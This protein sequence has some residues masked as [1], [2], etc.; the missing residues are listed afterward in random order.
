[1]IRTLRRL[2]LLALLLTAALILGSITPA[3]A[4]AA[5]DPKPA[6]T[7]SFDYFQ[8]V[9]PAL[10]DATPVLHTAT[11]EDIVHLFESEGNYAVLIGGAWD[12][13][14][15]ASI[16]YLNQVAKE[17]GVAAIYNF[18]TRLDGASLDITD[19]ANPFAFKYVDLVNKYLPNLAAA[20]QI[21]AGQ[22]VSYVNE[23]GTAVSAPKITA[24]YLFVYNKDHKDAAGNSA[25]IVASLNAPADAYAFQ[26]NGGLDTAK[27][28]AYKTLVR[29]TLNSAPTYARINSSAAIK[30]AFNKNYEAENPGKP[31]IF[32]AA[33]G[34]LVYEHITYHQ[35]QQLLASEGDY[36]LLFGGSWCPKTQAVIKYINQYAKTAGIDKVYFFDTKL[37]SGVT[38]AEPANNPD[39]LPHNTE[40]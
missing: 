20:G 27:V 9:Y 22:T 23:Q 8:Q 35:L 18:D 6:S 38:V 26:A 28:E 37:D 31:T 33:D 15:Q 10:K 4:V 29:Q 14:T 12:A 7:D 19:S 25:P 11:Y 3:P 32:T 39:K 30:A 17:L 5:A 24:P 34:D 2:P 40:T 16:G 21:A 36:A 1:M 13:H